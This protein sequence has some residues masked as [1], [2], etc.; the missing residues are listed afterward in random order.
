VEA[1]VVDGE[2]VPGDVEVEDGVV[3]A[4]GIGAGRH[5]IAVPGLVDLQV[6][7]FAGVDLLSEPERA[8]EV[9]ATLA[10]EGVTSWQPTLVTCPL[11]LADHAVPLLAAAPGSVG[12][13][14]EG[15]FLSPARAGAHPRELLREPDL[16]VLRELLDSGPVT[17]VTLAPELPG[18]L[19]LVDELVARGV[20]VSLGHTDATAEEA[21][22]AF[23]RGAS[24]VTHLFNAMRPL[25]HR[26]PGAAG[27]AL[28]RPD[29]T[30]QLIVDGVHVADEAVL[31]AWAAAR[32]RLAIVSDSIAAAGMGDGTYRL[33]EVDVQVEGGVCRTE[34]GALAGSASS[35]LAGLRNLVQLGIPLVEAVGAATTVPAQILGRADLGRLAPG[36]PADVV[37]LDDRLDVVRVLWRG[38]PIV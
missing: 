28:A 26:D 36:S 27:A 18:A 30:V 32:G 17:T 1:A 4:V 37:V 29:V 5:G 20:V 14:L 24:T 11:E 22:A 19:E 16:E 13:H 35:L 9:S 7:G 33:G 25:H 34:G 8:G 31:V 2:L 12:V 38:E 23:E 10:R 6:N 21:S 3:A 15:P